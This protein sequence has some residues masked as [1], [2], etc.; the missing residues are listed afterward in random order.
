MYLGRR[1]VDVEAHPPGHLHDHLP[2][3]HGAALGELAQPLVRPFELP[4][5]GNAGRFLPR[6]GHEAQTGHA[7]HLLDQHLDLRL[8][9]LRR[10]RRRRNKARLELHRVAVIAQRVV[11]ADDEVR[12]FLAGKRQ[13]RERLSAGSGVYA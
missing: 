9:H 4:L 13:D 2:L 3:R 10:I 12:R 7:V 8:E 11:A 5:A 6:T 1:V